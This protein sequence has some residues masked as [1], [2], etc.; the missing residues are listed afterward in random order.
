[1][2]KLKACSLDEARKALWYCAKFMEG[3]NWINQYARALKAICEELDR[4]AASESV[5]TTKAVEDANDLIR[6]LIRK[7]EPTACDWCDG[8]NC[9][10]CSLC[11]ENEEDE[12]NFSLAIDIEEPENK[13]LTLEQLRQMDGKPVW[14]VSGDGAV[15]AYSGWAIVGRYYDDTVALYVPDN[16]YYEAAVLHG[17]VLVYAR[18]PEVG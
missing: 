13:P 4:Q 11:T 3:T 14:V 18:K 16:V 15:C 17:T 8:K 10:A 7:M 9:E 12:C 1:M 5:S 2:D 6:A